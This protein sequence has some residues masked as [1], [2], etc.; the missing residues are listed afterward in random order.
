MRQMAVV[1][2][3]LIPQQAYADQKLSGS[4]RE[5]LTDFTRGMCVVRT[6][7]RTVSR[8]LSQIGVSR[9]ALCDCVVEEVAYTLT[10]E[11]FNYRLLGA[12]AKSMANA[13]GIANSLDET[14]PEEQE[15]FSIWDARFINALEFC[16]YS[17]ADVP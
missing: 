8:G 6:D 9:S 12:I 2:L 4:T 17:L 3:A 5:L 13:K 15:A 7:D 16:M 10:D 1:I 14:T 11:T